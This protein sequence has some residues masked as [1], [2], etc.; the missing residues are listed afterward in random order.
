M[1][2][3]QIQGSAYSSSPSANTTNAKKQVRS[4]GRIDILGPTVEQQFAMY[5]KIPARALHFAMP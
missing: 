4:N 1:Q 2:Y 3:Q 5:D